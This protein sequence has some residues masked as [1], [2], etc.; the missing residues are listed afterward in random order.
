MINMTNSE[1]RAIII[2][3]S[4]I[5]AS[6]LIQWFLP[7]ENRP[8]VYDYSHDDSLFMA[9]SN[10]TSKKNSTGST[11]IGKTSKKASKKAQNKKQSELKPKSIDINTAAYE[12]LTRLP[13]IGK[14]TATAILKYRDENGPFK[15]LQDLTKVNR[16][17]PKTLEKI[18]PY[19]YI[20]PDSIKTK[21][22]P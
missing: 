5:L 20:T 22:M 12:E 16:I 7:H 3:V 8:D 10:D 18:S 13:R 17:G 4:V 2:L 1:K 15:T 6:V 19:I 11:V 14:V 9:A 21:N